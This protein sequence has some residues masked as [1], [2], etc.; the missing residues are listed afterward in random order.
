MPYVEGAPP[1]ANIEGDLITG[2]ELAELFKVS[3]ATF[4][5]WRW[6]RDGKPMIPFVRLGHNLFYSRTQMAWWM[7]E[8][9]KIPDAH[10]EDRKQRIKEGKLVGRNR[11]QSKPV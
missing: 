1:I 6:G 3:I 10:H 9:Q 2:E 4:D 5:K 11:R 8:V 7:N